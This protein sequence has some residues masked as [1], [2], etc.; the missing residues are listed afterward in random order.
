MQHGQNIDLP[1]GR[2]RINDPIR[3]PG[4][5][6]SPRPRNLADT[7]ELRE[8]PEHHCSLEDPAHHPLGGALIVLRDP[9]ADRDQI[10]PRLRREVN[11]QA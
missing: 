3:Q 11:L 5:R 1:L 9:V 2:D 8:L 7:P 10:V 4:H 6:K